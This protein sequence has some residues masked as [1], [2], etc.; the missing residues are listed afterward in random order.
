MKHSLPD[1]PSSCMVHSSLCAL[2]C[3]HHAV[4]R[5]GEGVQH[6]VVQRE[7]HSPDAQCARRCRS[8][9]NRLDCSICDWFA[10]ILR[11]F[12]HVNK[13]RPRKRLTELMRTISTQEHAGEERQWD[14]IFRQGPVEFVESSSRPGRVGS[15]R[16][17]LNTLEG[18]VASRKARGVPCQGVTA[19]LQMLCFRCCV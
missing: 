13:L 2:G 5:W 7:T 17:E 16:L 10:F 6:Y 11:S 19:C 4:Q 1:A 3:Q 18:E 9:F 15:V 12:R 14:L 8:T